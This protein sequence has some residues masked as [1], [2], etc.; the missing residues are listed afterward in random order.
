MK[1]VRVEGVR[2]WEKWKGIGMMGVQKGVTQGWVNKDTRPLLNCLGIPL[3]KSRPKWNI[4]TRR[5]W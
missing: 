5:K 4:N 3:K 1:H 2:G